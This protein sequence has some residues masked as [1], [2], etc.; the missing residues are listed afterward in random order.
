[1]PPPETVFDRQEFEE[2]TAERGALTENVF[3]LARTL[4]SHLNRRLS[5]S[6]ANLPTWSVL[7]ALAKDE[8]VSQRELADE[9]RLEGPTITRYLD[10]LEARGIVR[11]RRDTKDRRIVRVSFTPDGKRYYGSLER[12][13]TELDDAIRSLLS[14]EE[15]HCLCTTINRIVGQMAEFD[16]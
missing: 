14:D 1:M 16:I 2:S 15:E 3:T 4:S 10:R 5:E 9:C 8:E 6:H 12:I 11:R 13:A 7:A